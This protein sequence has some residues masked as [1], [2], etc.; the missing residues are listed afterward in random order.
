M[1]VTVI[2]FL[3]VANNL[4]KMSLRMNKFF[5]Y[6]TPHW[7]KIVDIIPNKNDLLEDIINN[8]CYV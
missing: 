3:F 5:E 2:K 4:P 1:Y 7:K 8:D 6:W